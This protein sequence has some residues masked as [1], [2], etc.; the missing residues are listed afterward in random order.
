MFPV[1]FVPHWKWFQHPIFK[2]LRR[3]VSHGPPHSNPCF[4]HHTSKRTSE[5][6]PSPIFFIFCIF[7][8]LVR[9]LRP[10]KRKECKAGEGSHLLSPVDLLL[11][12]H[13]NLNC[14]W[15]KNSLWLQ[16]Y[17]KHQAGSVTR[18]YLMLPVFLN[19]LG[20]HVSFEVFKKNLISYWRRR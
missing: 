7:S 1:Y 20:T 9:S 17:S 10:Q 4:S 12:P 18:V 11:L 8:A 2:C 6:P 3:T 19:Q 15:G 5:L 14:L 13:F 16:S